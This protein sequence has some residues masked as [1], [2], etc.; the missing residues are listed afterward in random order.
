MKWSRDSA[1]RRASG[2]ASPLPRA[3]CAIHLPALLEAHRRTF[4]RLKVTLH[5]A[6][7]ALAETL[8]QK[9][10]I[11]LAITELEGKPPRAIKSCELLRLPLVLVAPA[12]S[13]LRSAAELWRRDTI[14][15]ALIA[16]PAS[17]AI[18]RLFAHGLRRA[19][20]TWSTGIEV[21]S[22]E[23]IDVY[24]TGGFGIGVSVAMPRATARD[25]VRT[26]P[27]RGFPPLVI[28]ALWQERLP[29]VAESFL[30][31]IKARAAGKSLALPR[32]AGDNSPR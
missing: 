28:A 6:N 30:A 24:A 21:T 27:L 13:T 1:A 15:E 7:Q 31:A 11:D 20:A 14:E 32:R 4:P 29:P 8:L 25:G 17:E 3:C 12:R 2:C 26:L 22:L 18:S 23:L 10:E 19:G 5:E 9:Q 16:L